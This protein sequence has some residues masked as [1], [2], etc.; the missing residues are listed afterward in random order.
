MWT[1]SFFGEG[2]PEVKVCSSITSAGPVARPRAVLNDTRPGLPLERMCKC[3]RRCLETDD[4]H[5]NVIRL[6]NI[7]C[8]S[9]G[10]FAPTADLNIHLPR[11]AGFIVGEDA[12]DYRRLEMRNVAHHEAIQPVP[13]ASREAQLRAGPSVPVSRNTQVQKAFDIGPGVAL[14]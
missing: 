4:I 8:V 10:R 9:T 6:N 13:E 12:E 3:S 5:G 2:T 7:L 1:A 14:E 11:W